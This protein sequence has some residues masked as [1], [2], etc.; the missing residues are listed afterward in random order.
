VGA[1]FVIFCRNRVPK[2]ASSRVLIDIAS[3]LGTRAMAGTKPGQPGKPVRGDEEVEPL[4]I[5]NLGD[6][7]QIKRVLDETA[8]AVRVCRFTSNVFSTARSPRQF[9][10]A[11]PV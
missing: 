8:V 5:L 7:A 9:R 4:K 3:H 2:T 11:Q 1:D 6:M 10:R